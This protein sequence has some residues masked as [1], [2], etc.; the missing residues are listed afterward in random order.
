MEQ[1]LTRKQA[2]TDKVQ[3]RTRASA[4]P[5]KRSANEPANELLQRMGLQ[6]LLERNKRPAN[7]S[8]ETMSMSRL[9]D[10]DKRPAI[11]SSSWASWPT[12]V[13]PVTPS[14][15]LGSHAGESNPR[16]STSRL[17]A[18]QADAPNNPSTTSGSELRASNLDARSATPEP[19]RSTLH[20]P[21]TTP[22]PQTCSSNPLAKVQIFLEVQRSTGAPKK[23]WSIPV[24]EMDIFTGELVRTRLQKFK[25][26]QDNEKVLLVH[27]R[28]E[29]GGRSIQGLGVETTFIMPW[30]CPEQKDWDGMLEGL[31]DFYAE[32]PTALDLKLRATLE[33]EA[34][35]AY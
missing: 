14:V 23:C 19:Q 34:D 11:G 15:A 6:G 26:L 30:D 24:E 8:P 22:G 1:R 25:L 10:R 31:K 29:D 16:P 7:H 3:L 18:G 4:N 2:P 35:E 21:S 12:T 33:V 9:H 17:Q 28:P 27:V 13:S 20:Y 5:L 32:Y